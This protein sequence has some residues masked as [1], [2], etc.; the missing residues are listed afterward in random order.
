MYIIGTHAKTIYRNEENGFTVGIIRVIETDLTQFQEETIWTGYAP[1]I[2]VNEDYKLSG[3]IVKHNKYG[4]QFS[5]FEYEKIIP[6]TNDKI[7]EYL[8]SDLFPGIGEKTAEKV[9]EFL[10]EDAIN[11]IVSN[12]ECM[13]ELQIS[14]KNKKTIYDVLIE[15]ES[16]NFVV[17]NLV[18]IGFTTKEA[19]KIYNSYR[20]ETLDL[21]EKNIY[22]IFYDIPE[23]TFEKIDN[24]ALKSGKEELSIERISTSIVH[25]INRISFQVGSS[26]LEYE[27]IKRNV[28][29]VIGF[30]VNDELFKDCLEDLK[31]DLKIVEEDEKFYLLDYFEAE[32]NISFFIKNLASQKKEKEKKIDEYIDL[33]TVKN[34]ISYNKKQKEAIKS[35]IL[36]NIT[37]ITGGPGVGKSTIIKGIIDT[38]K[39]LKGYDSSRLENEVALLAPTG[40]ASKRLREITGINAVT[41]HRF[42]KWNKEQNEFLVN[43][44]DKDDSKL[45]IVD[46]ASMVDILL[47]DSLI[48]GIQNNVKLI[49]VGD[50]NQLPSV[51]PGQ[52]FKDLIESELIDVIRLKKIYRQTE[53]SYIPI[54]SDF[55]KNREIGDFLFEKHT[56]YNFLECS[57]SNIMDGIVCLSKKIIDSGRTCFDFQIMAPIYRGRVGIDNINMQ[58]Q[59]LFNPKNEEKNEVKYGGVIYRVGDKVIQLN[60]MPEEDVYNGDIGKIVKIEKETSSGKNEITIDFYETTVI[61]YLSDLFNIKHA[62]C[63]SIHKSQGSEFDTVLIPM[64]SSYNKMLYN[65]LIYTGVT[66]AKRKLFL[67]GSKTAFETSILNDIELKRKTTLSERLRGTNEGIS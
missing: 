7:I 39:A 9:F 48:K 61:Y 6:K 2:R 51:L 42:L 64:C 66:R 47:F 62:Y 34:N 59:K 53:D 25:V 45:V 60:N 55:I 22:Q 58:L 8:S 3:E 18:E 20:E 31:I 50:Y 43:E 11:K 46:E 37:V 5:V 57:T 14:E 17:T 33:I 16:M 52:V 12:F 19:L 36:N 29:K 63:I 1:A 44:Y 24:I 26:F 13:K 35:A 23:I 10:G 56:D 67:I 38:Y 54:L 32:E 21:I 27:T 40:R 15:N 65:L 4:E 28:D 30:Y 41:I 49:I